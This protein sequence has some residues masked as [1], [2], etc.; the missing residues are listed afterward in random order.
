MNRL[1]LLAF[2]VWVWRA[3]RRDTA[4]R[5]GIS[6]AVWI[7]TLWVGILASRPVSTW[8]GFGGGAGGAES[9]EGSPVDMLFYFSCILASW[10]IVI[11]RRVDFAQVIRTNWPIFLFYGFL[12]VSV[13]WAESPFVSFKRW[14]KDF[15]NI[16]VALVVLSEAN[17]MQ[18]FRAVFV[19]CGYVLIPLSLIFVRYFP[20]L[21]RFYTVHSGELEVTGVTFQKNSLGAMILICSIV[22]IWDWLER[23]KTKARRLERWLPLL[24]VLIGLYLLHMCDSKTSMLCLALAGIIILAN[25]LPVMRNHLAA[26][27]P[28]MLVV[29]AAS[30]FLNST[31]EIEKTVVQSMG[32]DLTFTGRTDVWKV[33]LD[34][35]TNPVFGTGFCSFW[36][37]A[38]YQSKLPDW[39][40]F[41][42]HNGYIE[43]YIDGGYV[44]I[45]FL[46]IMLLGTGLNINRHIR[47]D[48]GQ[49]ALIRLAVFVATIVGN[50]AE[51]HYA[52]MSPLWFM[53]LLTGMEPLPAREPA[54]EPAPAIDAVEEPEAVA[55]AA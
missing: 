51:S 17:P 41:S 31:F 15:G 7:P 11:R 32:R 16:A 26:L 52:R 24:I 38:S 45:F 5:D 12:L 9:M 48:G 10:A 36:S 23:P 4:R 1:I 2:L 43:M 19:R 29:S 50:F 22:L 39:V 30:Y 25:R 44:G 54:F 55:P 40:A 37:D 46:V 3:I 27:A 53:F 14:L 8:I 47:R 21:G 18:A 42:A 34:A 49:Y 20:D 6:A 33:L 28:G 13:L 35:G